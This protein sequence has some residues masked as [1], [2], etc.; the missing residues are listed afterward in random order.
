MKK[1]ID[2]KK[3]VQ[4]S[5]LRTIELVLS[6]VQFRLFRAAITVAIISLA[7]A[8][9]T[10]M[11]GESVI[12]R[13][14]ASAINEETAPR[15]ML[16]YWVS[17]LSQPL[18]SEQLTSQLVRM[19]RDSARAKEFIAWGNL[20]PEELDALIASGQEQ[21]A[22]DAYFLSLNEGD[23]RSLVGR[24]RGDAIYDH[25]QD[26]AALET[27]RTEVSKVKTEFPTGS[28]EFDAFLKTWPETAALRSRVQQGHS[29]ATGTFRTTFL[30][31]ATVNQFLATCDDALPEQIKPMGFVMTP[32]ELLVVRDQA[33]LTLDA[34]QI[35]RMLKAPMV[36]LKLKE[37]TGE[38]SAAKVSTESLFV[39]LSSGGN[40]EKFLE[41]LTEL[42]E[43]FVTDLDDEDVMKKLPEEEVQ[44]LQ[45]S[46]LF[47]EGFDLSADR[48]AKVAAWKRREKE[49][50]DIE[51]KVASA[52]N[53]ES[54]PTMTTDADPAEGSA[55]SSR[56]IALISVSFLVCMVGIVNAM[57]MSVADRFREIATMKCLGATDGFIML[58]F[59]LESAVQGIV[60]GVI[61]AILGT[62]LGILRSWVAY[63]GMAMNHLPGLSLFNAAVLSLGLGVILSVL[64]AVYPAFVAARL[65]PMEAMRIE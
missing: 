49:L 48:T 59:M 20:S 46:R 25:L 21:A 40:A 41:A 24:P 32:D 31:N 22:Y 4:L 7:V 28:A 9:L 29:D 55:F 52:T 15:R 34:D 64:A 38:E 2:V 23:L 56:T 61:G 36:K 6:G 45:A 3:Q 65:A 57:L 12:A 43:R 17:Q 53:V 27:F 62:V 5:L 35:S 19:D 44:R 37:W 13:N 47:V 18:G 39:F 63:G 26:P 10:T 14:V 50:S 16:G 1:A 51:A 60:G 58:N 54:G 8:F 33:S 11:L 42:R 30:T